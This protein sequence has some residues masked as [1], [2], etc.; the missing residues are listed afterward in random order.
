MPS[1]DF[2]VAA[3]VAVDEGVLELLLH[4]LRLELD[5]GRL[6]VLHVAAGGDEE[7]VD[8]GVAADDLQGRRDLGEGRR[9]LGP[10]VADVVEGG[11]GGGVLA[12]VG[13]PVARRSR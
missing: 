7:V 10:G 11:G 2:G 6:Q 4:G 8:V 12:V 5:D 3:G 1:N 13:Q 9:A